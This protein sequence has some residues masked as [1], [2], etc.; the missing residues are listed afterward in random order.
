MPRYRALMGTAE[1]LAR[2]GAVVVGDLWPVK[3][4]RDEMEMRGE[5]PPHRVVHLQVDTGANMSILEVGVAAA[6]GLEAI[7]YAPLVAVSHRPVPSPVFRAE[8]R[9]G[10]E[11]GSPQVVPIPF[12][13]AGVPQT[14]DG[15]HFQGLLG[16]DFL[17]SYDLLYQGAA[18]RF[19]LRRDSW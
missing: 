16:R 8:L 12:T 5:I 2:G 9:I 15:A 17:R 1:H 7:R 14:F 4:A 19:E 18:G 6:L 3:H 10:F 11:N 13:F